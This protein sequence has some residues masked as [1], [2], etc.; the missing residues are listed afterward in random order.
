MIAHCMARVVCIS[1]WDWTH[2]WCFPLW[3]NAALIGS[4]W[5]DFERQQDSIHCCPW[6]AH[7]MLWDLTHP[8]LSIQ[9]MH[10]W[11]RQMPA[12]HHPQINCQG[13]WGQHCEVANSNTTHI[14]GWLSNNMQVDQPLIILHDPQSR[15][16]LTLWHNYCYFP[17]PQ[18][19]LTLCQQLNFLQHK[20]VSS[21]GEKTIVWWSIPTYSK[22]DSSLWNS[23]SSSTRI[24]FMTL[25]FNQECLSLSKIQVSKQTEAIKPSHAML[26][27][28]SLY[29]TCRSGHTTLPSSMEPS[30][31]SAPQPFAW[32]LAIQA[33]QHMKAVVL[34][35][36][37]GT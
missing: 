30:P 4:C 14:L 16:C 34:I 10:Q 15:A 21:R 20:S 24:P 19:S 31:T 7:K 36:T 29:T 3:R 35:S 26:V 1:N 17:H 28:W 18:I 8:D 27:W 12:P 9:L 37:E 33:G 23:S 5:G 22:A 13:M 6:L 25:T 11:H 32:S 2:A